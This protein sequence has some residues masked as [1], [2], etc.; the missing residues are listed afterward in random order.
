MLHESRPASCSL[1]V[2]GFG[3]QPLALGIVYQPR[4]EHWR[5]AV[6]PPV[7]DPSPGRTVGGPHTD[8]GRR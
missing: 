2:C 7:L 1:R 4:V 3:G 8:D 5:D 6:Y